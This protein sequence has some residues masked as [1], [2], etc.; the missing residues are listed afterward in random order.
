MSEENAERD[1][2]FEASTMGEDSTD[3]SKTVALEIDPASGGV[4]VEDV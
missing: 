3:N 1:D 2:N 4:M